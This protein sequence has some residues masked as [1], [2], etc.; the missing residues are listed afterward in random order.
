MDFQRSDIVLQWQWI[1][2]TFLFL[3]LK[4]E[5][6]CS[7]FDPKL[8]GLLSQLEEGLGSVVRQSG[9]QCSTPPEGHSEEDVLGM[10]VHMSAERR[11]SVISVGLMLG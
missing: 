3:S 6:W 1:L 8:A 10:H 7:E 5:P 4:D 2:N 9:A 11:F